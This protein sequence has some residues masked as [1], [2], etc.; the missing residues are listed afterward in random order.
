MGTLVSWDGD[1]GIGH[2]A[3]SDGGEEIQIH[4]SAFP[5]EGG[6]PR[7]GERL[8]FEVTTDK[9]GQKRASAV[10]RETAAAGTAVLPCRPSE[11]LDL[12]KGLPRRPLL[13]F[14]IALGLFAF[15]HWPGIDTTEIQQASAPAAGQDAR[16]AVEA[17]GTMPITNT[18]GR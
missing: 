6:K 3:L 17:T 7:I 5:R 15:K 12:R 2:V 4:A 9:D 16:P 18:A 11:I 10:G 1:R 14:A 13:L 8:W